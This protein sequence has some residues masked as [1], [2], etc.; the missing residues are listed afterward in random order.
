MAALL[1]LATVLFAQ[2][3]QV[4]P[5]I[6]AFEEGDDEVAFGV[7][8]GI[9]RGSGYGIVPL[10]WD[11]AAFGGMFSFGAEARLYWQKYDRFYRNWWTHYGWWQGHRIVWN[12]YHGWGYWHHGVFYSVNPDFYIQD[13]TYTRFG[14][15]PNFRFMFHP[16]GMPSIR[17]KVA[18]ARS[19]DP[20]AGIKLGFSFIFEDKDD[21]FIRKGDR[22]RFEFPEFNWYTLG[23]RWYFREHRSLWT[24]ISQYDFSIGFSFNF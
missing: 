19:I 9:N 10:V 18:A 13:Q 8:A 4:R 6:L 21:P 20:Y 1:V 3:G 14:I 17:G 15:N 5:R 16:F 11:R 12:N 7:L 23:L 22:V 24:E 2:T